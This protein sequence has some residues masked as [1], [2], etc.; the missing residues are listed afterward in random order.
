[1]KLPDEIVYFLPLLIGQVAAMLL[2]FK[3]GLYTGRNSN[4]PAERNPFNQEAKE[5][6][7]PNSESKKP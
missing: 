5:C 2:A 4:R 6:N 1:M 7:G 3:L